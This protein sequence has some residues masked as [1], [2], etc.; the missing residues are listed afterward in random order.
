METI[1]N[2]IKSEIPDLDENIYEIITNNFIELFEKN[3][4]NEKFLQH[5]KEEVVKGMLKISLDIYGVEIVKENILNQIKKEFDENSFTD[6]YYKD[7][8]DNI[9]FI[10]SIF[11]HENKIV[12]NDFSVLDEIKEFE[13][14]SFYIYDEKNEKYFSCRPTEI[15]SNLY[16]KIYLN[17]N[18]Y[19]SVL[20]ISKEFNTNSTIKI[21]LSKVKKI[22]NILLYG[23]HYIIGFEVDDKKCILYFNNSV[24]ALEGIIEKYLNK[25]IN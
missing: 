8:D 3:K 19:N 14:L 20:D 23:W 4:T 2:I 1:K 10:N 24:Y 13:E 18:N 9:S 22:F 16:F 7:Y 11:K 25:N 21:N 5:S 17:N 6:K 12:L 15:N